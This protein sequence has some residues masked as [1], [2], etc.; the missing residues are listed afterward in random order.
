M[1][2]RESAE[3]ARGLFDDVGDVDGGKEGVE[4]AWGGQVGKEEAA[5]SGGV[6]WR[7]R[8]ACQVAR[9]GAL[10]PTCWVRRQDVE[11]GA[12]YQEGI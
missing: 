1:T 7:L 3:A 10:K 12:V 9:V 8:G 5:G 11:A 4:N 6:L 2:L